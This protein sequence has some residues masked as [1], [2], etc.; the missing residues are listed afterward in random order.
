MKKCVV[1]IVL[2]LAACCARGQ[3]T[4]QYDQQSATS[5]SGGSG[6]S[7]Q[8]NQ[9]MGQS[10]TPTL[11]S[12]G[13]VQLEFSDYPD[14]GTAGATVYVNLLA[15]SITGTALESTTPVSMPDGAS[16][17]V[18]TF[19]FATPVS[20]T[21]GTT[22]YFQPVVVQPGSD[23]PWEIISAVHFNYLG[24]TFF[25]NGSPQIDHTDAWF[26]EGVI[27]AP[28]PSCALLALLGVTGF[29]FYRRKTNN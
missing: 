7:I 11:S 10:F 15:N 24:G 8:E 28:E 26:R 21:P 3:G 2:V 25:V 4:F 20:V 19:L 9:P 6:F 18:A 27:A 5:P 17:Y 14:N 1:Q 29:Y 23:D 12:V 22:Y 16:D 13:F